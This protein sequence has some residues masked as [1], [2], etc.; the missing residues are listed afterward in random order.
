MA[1][2]NASR[3]NTHYYKL[4]RVNKIKYTVYGSSTNNDQS[5]LELELSIRY[6]NPNILVTYYSKSLYFFQFDYEEYKPI[7]DNYSDLVS[8]YSNS[9]EVDVFANP[10]KNTNN[11]DYLAFASLGF[12]KALKKMVMFNLSRNRVIEIF[13]NYCVLNSDYKNHVLYLDPILLT[14][15]D[16]LLS[17]LVKP[18]LVLYNTSIIENSNADLNFVIYLIPSGIRC[19]FFDPKVIHNNFIQQKVS[20]DKLM[21]SLKYSIG[22]EISEEVTWVKLIPNLKHLNNQTSSISKFIHEVD[23][24]KF[25]LWPWKFCLLQFGHIHDI[26]DLSTMTNVSANP[27]SL[28]SEF[29]DFNVTNSQRHHQHVH[30][31]IPNS[32]SIPSANS[33]GAS[34]SGL[35]YTDRMKETPTII[36]SE[37][38]APDS[39]LFNIPNSVDYF[40]EDAN[41]RIDELNDNSMN[42][43]NDNDNDNDNEDM[44]LDDLFGDESDFLDD[45]EKALENNS[46]TK[47]MS[48]IDISHHIDDTKIADHDKS[49][50]GEND[51]SNAD[52]IEKRCPETNSTFIEIPKDQMTIKKEL[53]PTYNDP[54]APLPI[55]PTPIYTQ[56]APPLATNPPIPINEQS[57]KSVFSPILFNPIIKSNIDTKYGRGGKFYVQ[58]E[59]SSDLELEKRK[60]IRATSVSGIEIPL[61]EHD[62]EK[63]SINSTS[64]DES[65][66]DEDEE[67]NNIANSSPLKLNMM[68]DPYNYKGFNFAPGSLPEKQDLNTITGNADNVSPFPFKQQNITLHKPESPFFIEDRITSLSPLDYDGQLKLH[69]QATP[70]PL[71]SI[72]KSRVDSENEIDKAVG[73]KMEDTLKISGESSNY[74]PL[75]LRSINVTTIPNYY[76]M[77]NLV[78][79]SLVPYLSINEDYID[80]DNDFDS[81]KSNE[82]I[83]KLVHINEFLLFLCPNLIFDLGLNS[84]KDKIQPQFEKTDK[85]IEYIKCDDDFEYNLSKVFPQS[86]KVKLIE[87]LKES[88]DYESELDSQLN[89]LNEITNTDDILTPKVIFNKLKHIE[90]DSFSNHSSN[91]E[92]FQIYIELIEKLRDQISP[93]NNAYFKIPT[94]KIRVNKNNNIINL[95]S[96]AIKFWNYLNFGPINNQKNIQVLMISE[97]GDYNHGFLNNLIYNY[98]DANLGEISKVDLHSESDQELGINDGLLLINKEVG[99]AYN[100][101]YKQVNNKLN[102]LAELIKLDLINKTNRFEFDR[103]LLL[104]FVN[105]NHKL[106]S[107]LHISKIF[108]N[109]KNTLDNHQLPLVKIFTKIIPGSFLVKQLSNEVSPKFLSNAKLTKLSMNLYNQCPND[110]I[111]KD[112]TTNPFTQIVKEPPTNIQFKFPNVNL[113]DNTSL[114]SLNDDI[115]LHLAYER[116][117]DRNWIAAAWSDP[118]GVV[119]YS[120]TWFCSPVFVSKN[121]GTFDLSTITNEIWNISTKLFDRLNDKVSNKASGLGG[122]KFLVLTRINSIIPDDELIHWKRLSV[123]HKDI[124]LI[125]L[126]VNKS[127]KLIFNNEQKLNQRDSKVGNEESQQLEESGTERT[128]EK[129][130]DSYFKNFNMSANSSP[131][132]A[133][134]AQSYSPNGINLNSPQQLFNVPGMFLTPQDFPSSVPG[135]GSSLQTM[136]PEAYLTVDE[137]NSEIIGVI[138]KRPLPSFN[139][140]TRL[141]MKIGYLLKKKEDYYLVFEVNLLS[142]SNFWDLNVIM[143]ILLQQYKKLIVLNDILGLRDIDG[144]V[145]SS[146]QSKNKKDNYDIESITPWHILAVSKALEYLIHV[147]IEE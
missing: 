4:G 71:L 23:N 78:N 15:G 22:Y 88:S 123:K 19:H 52:I 104:L 91:G 66:E 75:I 96:N 21:E 29:I 27:L 67:L 119:T 108:N 140:P 47:S 120:K 77:N 97:N 73:E 38:A 12:L 112:L 121:K 82:M 26:K 81:S 42:N 70:L 131:T 84:F 87:F 144:D 101:F 142:C 105:F 34:F 118:L 44:E 117:I 135:S 113:K 110:L 90:W 60:N 53:S 33:T 58:K 83:I 49:F 11:D 74:L 36:N 128:M 141:S 62:N 5:L 43:N 25:I 13:G 145:E 1:E 136:A 100:E 133:N 124:S 56:S 107:M 115:F 55:M 40:K 20:N 114:N 35:M 129:N 54:G 7:L 48:D 95:N 31:M 89:F 126:S 134:I 6:N 102:S 94:V 116:S 65:D 2:A 16:I 50:N 138:P 76:L 37:V 18:Q 98:K 14:S 137:Y 99:H 64:S 139:S 69:G 143:K 39:D 106:N 8:K 111:S 79:S 130:N 9:V 30:S 86:Y 57:G 109:F 63:D 17:A 32:L 146:T 3:I 51:K 147:H 28:I 68:N 45:N 41:S 103:P 72:P 125:V 85:S 24:K 93:D 61:K 132:G 92:M 10:P 127:P 46:E 122:K 80:F 59:L